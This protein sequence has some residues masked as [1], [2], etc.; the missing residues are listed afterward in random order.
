MAGRNEPISV[1]ECLSHGAEVAER[2]SP[3]EFGERDACAHHRPERSAPIECPARPGKCHLI[4]ALV[5]ACYSH[6]RTLHSSRVSYKL[7][8]RPNHGLQCSTSALFRQILPPRNIAK[9]AIQLEG[10]KEPRRTADV[11][12]ML[13]EPGPRGAPIRLGCRRQDETGRAIVVG[14]RGWYVTGTASS[15]SN[16]HTSQNPPAR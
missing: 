13:T 6:R 11:S 7:R 3:E 5:L 4:S 10:N 1:G 12:R 8:H 2:D 9:V 16:E 15:I 14:Q